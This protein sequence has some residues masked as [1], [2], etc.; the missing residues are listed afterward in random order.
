MKYQIF[1][2]LRATADITSAVSWYLQTD[3]NL[4][5]RFL[6]EIHTTL[7]RIRRMPYAFPKR[8][9]VLRR[10]L[11]RRFPYLIFYYVKMNIVS[12][13]AVIHERRSDTP[14]MN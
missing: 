2:S 8:G 13:N 5:L 3:P 14:W 12:I 6:A 10:A 9:G 7:E 11:V 1:L 4:A